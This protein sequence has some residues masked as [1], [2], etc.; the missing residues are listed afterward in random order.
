MMYKKIIASFILMGML[1]LG[2]SK[3]DVQSVNIRYCEDADN[4]KAENNKTFFVQPGKE[5]EICLYFYTD[6]LIPLEVGY[7]FPETT[8]NSQGN[9]SC[10]SDISPINAFSKYFVGSWERKFTLSS[11]EPYMVKE[12][13]LAPMGM[14]WELNGCI[15]YTVLWLADTRSAGK[16][17]DIVVRKTNFLSFFV[18]ANE[19]IKN[20]I[21]L[22]RN[23]WWIYSTN[24]DIKATIDKDGKFALSFLVKN[25]GNISQNVVITGSVHNMLGFEK[26]YEGA[27]I[28]IG[29]GETREIVANI[30]ILPAYK[31]FFTIDSIIKNDPIFGFDTSAMDPKL[32]TGS[33]QTESATVYIFSWVTLIILIILILILIKIILPRKVKIMKQ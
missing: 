30:G 26:I 13:F 22:V 24:S 15:A 5:K 28:N 12:R 9:R 16:I 1:F 20:N 11:N 23:P 18:W 25:N 8:L 27:P 4:P 32:K 3:A 10:S 29:P 14:S 2:L 6:S 33:T 7:S 17:F 31:W 19:A 21:Q